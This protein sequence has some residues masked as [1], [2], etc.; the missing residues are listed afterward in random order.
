MKFWS[1]EIQKKITIS[2]EV[3]V[4]IAN[5]NKSLWAFLT[6]LCLCHN[7]VMIKWPNDQNLKIVIEKSY[8]LVQYYKVIEMLLIAI[9]AVDQLKKNIVLIIVIDCE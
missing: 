4:I 6:D 7:N 9:S 5:D 1:S 8:K 2:T 3:K